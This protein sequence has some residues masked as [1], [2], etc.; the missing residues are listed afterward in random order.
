MARTAG[1]VKDLAWAREQVPKRQHRDGARRCGLAQKQ[2]HADPRKHPAVEPT[3]LLA[4]VE[5]G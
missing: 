3:A 5:P 4:G 2:V 1:G